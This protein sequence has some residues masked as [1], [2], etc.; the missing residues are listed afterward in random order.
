MKQIIL[1]GNPYFV[2]QEV[3]LPAMAPLIAQ[4]AMMWQRAYKDEGAVVI[5]SGIA[6]PF[7]PPRCKYSRD[8]V[9]IQPFGQG[10]GKA[11]VKIPINYL[12]RHGIA[13]YWECGRRD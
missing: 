4:A 6:I 12:S 11:S 3:D 5:G 9:I 13:C 10:D 2:Y 7:L 8:K 1:G